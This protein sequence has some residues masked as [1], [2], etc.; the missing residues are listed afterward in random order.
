MGNIAL[1]LMARCEELPPI[2]PGEILREDFMLPTRVTGKTA[3]MIHPMA[4][5]R[6]DQAPS[7]LATSAAPTHTGSYLLLGQERLRLLEF[8]AFRVRLLTK[9]H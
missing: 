3:S 8:S 4:L 1:G 2:H 5:S 9:G 6:D 7:T